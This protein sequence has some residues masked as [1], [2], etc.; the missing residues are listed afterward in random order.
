MSMWTLR[1]NLRGAVWVIWA[2]LLW[3]SAAQPQSRPTAGSAAPGGAPAGKISGRVTGEDK[4]GIA[5]V[6]VIVLGTKQGTMTDE[7]GNFVIAGVPAG[8]QQLR[9]QALG[10]EAIVQPVQVNVGQ[11]ATVNFSFGSAKIAQ[12]LEEIEVRAEKR[13][14]TKSS[15]TKQAN[16]ADKLRELPVDNLTQAVATKAGVVAASDGLHFRG[17][18]TG[19]VKF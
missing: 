14:D 1:K 7:N 8:T 9:A 4:Q 2:T 18:R 15:T 5:F 13:I 11:T 17:G 6:N 12:T 3:T 19:E 16:S 10:Y